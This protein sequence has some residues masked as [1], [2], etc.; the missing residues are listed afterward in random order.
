MDK[1]S[2]K[3]VDSNMINVTK[4]LHVPKRDVC[5][6][7]EFASKQWNALKHDISPKSV[8]ASKQWNVQKWNKE[9]SKNEVYPLRKV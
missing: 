1:N 5:S 7:Y 8:F 4:A 2:A 9:S 6:K 3:I